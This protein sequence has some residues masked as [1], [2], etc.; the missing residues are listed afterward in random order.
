MI[1]GHIAGLPVE[2]TILQLAPAALAVGAAL[3]GWLRRLSS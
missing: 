2:E 1:Y 3:R